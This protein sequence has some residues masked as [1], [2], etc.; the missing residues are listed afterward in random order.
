[1]ADEPESVVSSSPHGESRAKRSRVD[2]LR[3]RTNR[4]SQSKPHRER[5]RALGISGP[6]FPHAAPAR[7]GFSSRL[8]LADRWSSVSTYWPRY[9]SRSSGVDQENLAALLNRGL[10]R[11]A[12]NVVSKNS[13]TFMQRGPGGCTR[14]EVRSGRGAPQLGLIGRNDASGVAT[15]R[16]SQ[17]P[18]ACVLSCGASW[19]TGCTKFHHSPISRR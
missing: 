19:W 10:A 2:A 14:G 1:M 13:T 11:V 12:E 9:N 8:S 15:A 7:H 6:Q 17:A 18:A 3:T 5:R 4:I 16:A